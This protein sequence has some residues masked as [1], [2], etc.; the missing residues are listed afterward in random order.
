MGHGKPYYSKGARWGRS[1]A[2]PAA[3]SK[4]ACATL[5]RVFHQIEKSIV[6]RVSAILHI[7]V[8]LEQPK[9]SYFGELAIPVAFQLAR[10]LRQAP[11]RL[12]PSWWPTRAIPGVAALEVAGNGYINIRSTAARYGGCCCCTPRKTSALPDRQDHRR[13]HQYQSQQGRAHRASAQCHSGRHVRAHAAGRRARV[14]VQNYIDNTGVQVA[15]VVVGFHHLE[16][17][18]LGQTCRRSS[19]T[20][21]ERFDYL[22]WDLYARTS[23]YYKEHPEALRLAQ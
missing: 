6:D 12:R 9:Q 7:P 8:S 10:Q 5:D 19:R 16:T 22:C 4:T 3:G 2:C 21:T 11:E 23:A 15:D 1:L 13:A 18:Q 17:S 20:P 14:E